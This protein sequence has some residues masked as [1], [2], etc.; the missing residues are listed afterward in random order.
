MLIRKSVL[1][2]HKAQS[3]QALASRWFFRC[4][5]SA[6][7]CWPSTLIGTLPTGSAAMWPDRC[8][9]PLLVICAIT[10]WRSS[11]TEKFTTISMRN[12]TFSICATIQWK[13]NPQVSN[14]YSNHPNVPYVGA[15]KVLNQPCIVVKDLDIIKD[16]LTTN[17]ES[18][19]D[20]DFVVNESL[21]PLI[22]QN[23]FAASGSN[24]KVARSNM[25]PLFTP[26][27]VRFSSKLCVQ[28][29]NYVCDSLDQ[30]VVSDYWWYLCAF[31]GLYQRQPYRYGRC[32]GNLNTC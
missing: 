8:R 10:Y 17:F 18:F 13:L 7:F 4:S 24:W 30:I 21:D 1:T 14:F 6:R 12:K 15:Y 27:K 25:A 11:T 19:H 2:E 9:F 20:N 32:Q 5:L 28:N 31:L 23:P 3:F 22:S 16:I 29:S 26:A